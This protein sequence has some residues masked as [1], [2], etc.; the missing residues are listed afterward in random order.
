[1]GSAEPKQY[2]LLGDK[3]II[4]H[5]I[6]AF[7]SSSYISDIIVV[8]PKT[9]VVQTEDL[10][11]EYKVASSSVT[12]V[13]GGARRQDSVYLGLLALSGSNDVVLVH[14]GARPLVSQGVIDRCYKGAVKHGAVIA[15][16][17]VKDT[18][19]KVQQDNTV[20]ATVDRTCLF[21]AQTPQAA[22]HELLLA[23]YEGNGDRDVTDESSL[24]ERANIP[25]TIVEGSETNIKVT[26]PEDLVLAETIFQQRS[27][28]CE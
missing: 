8:V 21:Q 6:G 25:V 11:Q 3:P 23:A 24:F 4:I 17:P 12:V 20:V 9:R 10:L 2:L 27:A 28:P 13:A 7:L 16:V 26:R 22:R 15:A 1:M 18:L 5:T 14:D 19:K